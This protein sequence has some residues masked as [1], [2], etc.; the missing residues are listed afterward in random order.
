MSL[1]LMTHTGGTHNNVL[2]EYLWFVD[3]KTGLRAGP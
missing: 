2:S 1:K 3:E